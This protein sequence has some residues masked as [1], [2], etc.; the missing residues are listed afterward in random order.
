MTLQEEW[1]R[2]DVHIVWLKKQ[3]CALHEKNQKD[4]TDNDHYIAR[5]LREGAVSIGQY[6]YWIL[7]RARKEGVTIK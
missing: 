7:S 2:T 6:R 1:D 4:W 5:E 3:F